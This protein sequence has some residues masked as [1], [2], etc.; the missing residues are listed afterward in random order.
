M[1]RVKWDPAQQPVRGYDILYRKFE[2]VYSGRW[3]LKEIKDPNAL[4]TEIIVNKPENS[5]IVVVQGK[6]RLQKNPFQQHQF[7]NHMGGNS[8][9]GNSMAQPMIRG[10]PGNMMAPGQNPFESGNMQMQG[11]PMSGGQPPQMQPEQGGFAQM[12]RP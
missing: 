3:Q 1:L 4:A 6:P 8:M 7:G 12:F 2:W 9:G 10:N 5:F 11:N